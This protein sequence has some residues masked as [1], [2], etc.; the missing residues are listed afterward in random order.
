MQNESD[1]VILKYI[2]GIVVILNFQ[3]KSKIVKK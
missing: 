3:F 2:W 1:E